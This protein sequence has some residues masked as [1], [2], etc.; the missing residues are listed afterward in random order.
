M[1]SSAF[2]GSWLN[3]SQPIKI[4]SRAPSVQL[5]AQTSLVSVPTSQRSHPVTVQRLSDRP[6]RRSVTDWL[7]SVRGCRGGRKG[8]GAPR[9]RPAEGSARTAL[10]AAVAAGAE[11]E[12]AGRARASSQSR[13]SC[14]RRRALPPARAAHLPARAAGPA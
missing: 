1:I 13:A 12:G 2:P 14:R 7:P 5:A 3:L 9:P 8:P 10:R 4:H 6:S 11:A